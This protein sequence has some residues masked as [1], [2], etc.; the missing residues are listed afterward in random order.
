[1]RRR[2][3][4]RS[5]ASL[6]FAPILPLVARRAKAAPTSRP[7]GTEYL[8]HGR[9]TDKEAFVNFTAAL[10]EVVLPKMKGQFQ[11]QMDAHRDMEAL[12]EKAR[13]WRETGTVEL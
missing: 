12:R 11:R 5:L 4:L 13:R 10:K 6:I 8:A 9:I 3:A 7:F 2:E 1:M